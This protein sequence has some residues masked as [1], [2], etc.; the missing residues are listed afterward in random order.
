M[1]FLKEK[2]IFFWIDNDHLTKFIYETQ[3]VEKCLI[4]GSLAPFR[5]TVLFEDPNNLGKNLRVLLSLSYR[6]TSFK[7]P[8]DTGVQFIYDYIDYMY[9]FYICDE[10]F[11]SKKGNT[12]RNSKKLSVSSNFFHQDSY[13]HFSIWSIFGKL[14][15]NPK[16]IKKRVF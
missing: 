12:D 8:Y 16:T 9:D 2:N 13:S 14:E 6:D 3:F 1:I 7:H 5:K 15:R 11:W 4:G 10:F